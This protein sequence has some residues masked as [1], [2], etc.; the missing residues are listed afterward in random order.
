M[1]Q[2][3]TTSRE[4]RQQLETANQ[5]LQA[6]RNSPTG[7]YQLQQQLNQLAGTTIAKAAELNSAARTVPLDADLQILPVG[8]WFSSKTVT[9]SLKQGQRVALFDTSAVS[10]ST[11]TSVTGSDN[12]AAKATQPSPADLAVVRTLQFPVYNLYHFQLGLGFIYSTAEDKRF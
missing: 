1:W 7:V 10:D 3:V 5:N 9:V 11:R 12:P 6:Q 8:Q 2:D 4:R